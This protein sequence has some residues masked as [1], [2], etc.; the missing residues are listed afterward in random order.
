MKKMTVLLLSVMMVFSMLCPVMADG[1]L[2]E[3]ARISLSENKSYYS[4]AVPEGTVLKITG[5]DAEGNERA[6]TD[7]SF[8]YTSTRPWVL[9]IDENGYIVDGGFDGTTIVTAKA[10]N[11][12]SASLIFVK[13]PN[14]GYNQIGIFDE[15]GLRDYGSD[16]TGYHDFR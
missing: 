10:S 1:E 7:M 2:P 13:S 15:K 9:D 8:T 14:N 3:L 4:S 11:G 5:Y 12:V 16:K 6:L